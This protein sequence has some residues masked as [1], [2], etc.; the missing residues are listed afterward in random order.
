MAVAEPN[1]RRAVIPP[2][3]LAQQEAN[4]DPSASHSRA[5]AKQ[6]AIEL[7][8][9]CLQMTASCCACALLLQRVSSTACLQLQGPQCSV[10]LG[11][12]SMRRQAA[13]QAAA[14]TQQA[15]CITAHQTPSWRRPQ[16]AQLMTR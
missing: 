7:H 14:M 5:S 13:A 3:R 11:R 16:M 9:A 2:E 1:Q 15:S 6:V 12:L 4:A 8:Y 10:L